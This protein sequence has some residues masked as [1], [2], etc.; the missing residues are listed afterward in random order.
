MGWGWR[1]L[2]SP[3]PGHGP[4]SHLPPWQRPGWLWRGRCWW[5][6][7]YWWWG[8]PPSGTFSSRDE[9]ISYLT[10]IEKELR[11]Q[12]KQIEERLRELEKEG[13]E[14]KS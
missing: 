5:Y 3:W 14:K 4:F 1:R 2:W 9:E 13:G 7:W 6:W 11:D 12:L 10:S 8:I